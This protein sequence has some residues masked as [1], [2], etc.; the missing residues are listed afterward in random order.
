MILNS[1]KSRGW[2]AGVSASTGTPSSNLYRVVIGWT[3]CLASGRAERVTSSNGTLDPSAAACSA[4]PFC[5]A[6][7]RKSAAFF[8]RQPGR[9]FD[10]GGA[11]R[12]FGLIHLGKVFCGPGGSVHLFERPLPRRPVLIDIPH[13]LLE[14]IRASPAC[15]GAQT[16]ARNRVAT[17][18][19]G[20][21]RWQTHGPDG[22]SCG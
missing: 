20:C 19:Q 17:R 10:L 13:H 12:Y 9:R 21:S 8:V 15:F 18:R 16:S 3:G 22:A 1:C 5:P 2:H 11:S 14:R 4:G 7:C 6:E